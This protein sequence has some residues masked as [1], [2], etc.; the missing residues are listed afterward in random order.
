MQPHEYIK[1]YYD[2]AVLPG[3]WR[4][5]IPETLKMVSLYYSGKYKTGQYDDKNF[6]KFFYN[7]TKPS[8]DIAVKFIDLDSKDVRLIPER[9]G[10]EWYTWLFERQLK[11]WM[12]QSHFGQLLNEIVVDFPKFG[13]II[14]KKAGGKLHR[15]NIE[16]IRVSPTEKTLEDPEWMYELHIWDRKKVEGVGGPEAI[17][18]LDDRC[19]KQNKYVVYEEYV[20]TDSGFARRFLVDVFNVLEKDGKTKSSTEAAINDS[21]EYL[22]PVVLKEDTVSKVPYYELKWEE[23]PGRWLGFG[24]VEYLEDNQVAVNETE[25]LERKALMFKAINAWYTADQTLGGQNVL[26]DFDNGDILLTPSQIAPLQKDNA[27]LS[28]YNNTRAYWKENTERKTFTSDIT[29]GANLPS[30]TPLGVANLQAQFATSYFEQKR[31]NLGMFIRRLVEECVI[32]SLL[33]KFSKKHTQVFSG[34]DLEHLHEVVLRAKTNQM[35]NR[36]IDRTG[37][38]PS[39]VMV[40]DFKQQVQNQLNNTTQMYV[41]V[42]DNVYKNAK[43]ST[44]VITTGESMD[45]NAQ[46]QLLSLALQIKN[47]N[48]GIDQDPT[49]R[50]ILFKLLTL[51]GMSPVD[52]QMMSKKA[53]PQPIVPG[54][55]VSAPEIIPPSI[56]QQPLSV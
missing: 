27:D 41:E 46:S 29:T 56:N 48:P 42:P 38:A 2:E 21:Y 19:E 1:E 25:N 10:D 4:Y 11:E 33:P 13:H 26:S 37:Y 8:C 43:Y 16:N 5:S 55:S 6:R 36:Y 23:I 18:M 34:E 17:K 45:I 15:V 44:R 49:G 7:I 3:G 12:D 9:S 30:R 50:A 24:F 22:P 35:I 52:L 47:S 51:G 53:A 40:D 20:K 39:Q 31:E 28:A 32:P 14:I 54:G